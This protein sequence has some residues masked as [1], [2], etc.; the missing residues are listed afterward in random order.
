M[1]HDEKASWLRK[2][3]WSTWYNEDY[4][5]HPDAVENPKIQDHTDYGLTIDDAIQYECM[6]KPKF[7]PMGLPALSKMALANDLNKKL[8][9]K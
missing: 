3:G 7:Q 1:T 4:W 9:L 8:G 2:R 5:V 6:G